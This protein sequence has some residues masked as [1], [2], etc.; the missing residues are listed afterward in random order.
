MSYIITTWN[1]LRTLEWHLRRLSMQ[2]WD[3][4]FEVIVCVD[5]STDGT[6]KMLRFW[7]TN[8]HYINAQKRG[9]GAKYHMRWY[10]TGSVN[11]TTP[12]KARNLG[13]K[14]ANGELL[15]FADDDCLPHNELIEQYAKKFNPK[16][17][18]I[19]YRS[20][21]QAYLNKQLPVPIEEGKMS[22]I[23]EE[24]RRGEFRAG[25][26]TTGSGAMSVEAARTPA[27][28]GNVGFDERF[29]GYGKEDSE[30][31]IRLGQAGYKFIWNPD[32]V[33][34]HINPSGANQQEPVRK[35]KELE[36]A[37]ILYSKIVK[38][39]I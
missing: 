34:W 6:Q 17:I 8:E 27:K 13:I 16:E 20:S 30:F 3:K 18:Q 24:N 19:G 36:K 11:E 37:R 21:I 2:T 5:G 31:A 39:E 29:I 14:H 35:A 28:D 33:I 7:D 9:Y 4:P 32:A 26:F 15:I 25:H 38:N 10:D 22:V 12:A 23:A 1:R